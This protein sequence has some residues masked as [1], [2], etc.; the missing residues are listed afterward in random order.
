MPESVCS[1]KN[2]KINKSLL[3]GCHCIKKP[4]V[5]RT[6]HLPLR[7]D[8]DMIFVQCPCSE[9]H[10]IFWYT[11]AKIYQLNLGRSGVSQIR[12]E[13]PFESRA[14]PVW[15]EVIT[16]PKVGA[17]VPEW[18]AVSAER[19]SSACPTP[20]SPGPEHLVENGVLT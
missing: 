19:C 1:R 12:F 4:E 18:F 6:H 17:V 9:S 7:R 15:V 16:C 14:R 10:C 2:F 5:Y 20:L 3:I 8:I 11:S 13:L